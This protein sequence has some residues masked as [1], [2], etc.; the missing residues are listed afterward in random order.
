MVWI[1]VLLG[2]MTGALLNLLADSLPTAY[3]VRRPRCAYC[4]CDRQLVAW[5]AVSATLTNNHRCRHCG[6]PVSLRHLLVEL[7][8]GL[9]FAFCWLRTGASIRTVFDIVYS[10]AF[11]LIVVT[12]IEHRLIQHVITLPVIAVAL[13]GAFLNPVF[14]SPNRA[15]LGGAIGLGATFALYLLG[16]L[17]V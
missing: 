3:R 5:S 1:L 16:G 15:L 17:F 13:V 7:V 10:S 14:D 2:L 12:D 8:T 6:A 4:G 11:V 9:L